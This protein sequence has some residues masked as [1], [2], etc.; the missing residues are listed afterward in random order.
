MKTHRFSSAVCAEVMI[1]WLVIP[2]LLSA[3]GL[4]QDAERPYKLMVGDAAPAISVSAWARG[5]S[6]NSLAKGQVYVV[7]FWAT[8]CGPC[9]E[10]I[11]HLTD[12][13]RKY[14]SQVMIIGISVWES[15]PQNVPAFIKKMGSKMDY[16]VA[17]DLVPQFP[18]EVKSKP[19]F[20]LENGKSSVDW[21]VASGWDENGIPVAF[22][23]DRAGRI[24]WIGE[25]LGGSLDTPLEE[26]IAG[27][28]NTDQRAEVYA[29]QA[30]ID[31]KVR[32]ILREM[33]TAFDIK[34]YDRAIRLSEEAM[35]LD[36]AQGH[37]AGFKFEVLLA[38]K[39]DLASAYRY[40]TEELK[41]NTFYAAL[42]QMAWII[43]FEDSRTRPEDINLA[44][45]LATRANELSKGSRPG[46]QNTLAR[47]AYL[48]KDY[49][50]AVEL[51]ERAIELVKDD[52]TK[53]EFRKTLAEY[54]KALE[55]SVR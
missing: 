41:S 33:N 18:P 32:H 46:I 38:H 42:G 7:E 35:A 21:L 53:S 45:S 50:R 6:I 54:I 28:W 31:K 48:E 51:Q 16:A 19:R 55:G 49:R 40:A 4:A 20:A 2:T 8:W 44:K 22:V 23:I 9:L 10:S 52:E 43:I 1:F 39:K 15:E 12:L 17:Q 47:I 36:P 37:L 27:R 13:Q 26:V 11:P 24:A 29:K 14:G 5:N 30:V 34:E 3:G 25:P